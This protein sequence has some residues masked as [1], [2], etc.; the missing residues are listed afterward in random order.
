[1]K[2]EESKKNKLAKNLNEAFKKTDS[3][4]KLENKDLSEKN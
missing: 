3:N 2:N 1:M 4:Q